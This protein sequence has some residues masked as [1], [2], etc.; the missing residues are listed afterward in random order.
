MH[1]GHD[2]REKVIAT[3]FPYPTETTTIL[4]YSILARLLRGRAD[5]GRYGF[6]G[7]HNRLAPGCG[8]LMHDMGR[9]SFSNLPR[10][11]RLNRRSGDGTALD[12]RRGHHNARWRHGN[13][14]W[15][16]RS[17]HT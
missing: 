6:A 3:L 13:G 14:R 1:V 9:R 17:Q 12:R 2:V 16:L 5:D 4:A 15:R 7:P 8:S 11:R 10:L